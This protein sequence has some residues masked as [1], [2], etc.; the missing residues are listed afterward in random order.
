MDEGRVEGLRAT[1][2]VGTLWTGVLAVNGV[3]LE[4]SIRHT[5]LV[6]RTEQEKCKEERIKEKKKST[7]RRRSL[8]GKSRYKPLG[9][10]E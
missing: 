7:K 3:Y 1:G 8:S 10:A 5:S 6:K 2:C 9:Y 4:P